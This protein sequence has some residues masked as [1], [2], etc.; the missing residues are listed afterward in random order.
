MQKCCPR[1]KNILEGNMFG[2]DSSKK[3]GFKYACKNCTA[4]YKLGYDKEQGRRKR[5]NIDERG[6]IVIA[7]KT[8]EEMIAAR[9]RRLVQ[10]SEYWAKNA[11]NMRKLCSEYKKNNR[12]KIRFLE[13]KQMAIARIN[14]EARMNAAQ[15]QAQAT[16]TPQQDDASD[17]ALNDDA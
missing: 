16:L 8:E 14:A 9:T 2:L 7:A 15:V 1:C 17:E 5:S 3:D 12:A 10:M 6:N 13:G 4:K 11:D